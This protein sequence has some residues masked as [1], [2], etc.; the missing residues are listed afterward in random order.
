MKVRCQQQKPVASIRGSSAR[1]R[2]R[3]RNACMGREGMVTIASYVLVKGYASTVVDAVSARNVE[4]DQYAC[5]VVDAICALNVEGDQYASTVVD[6]VSARNVEGHQYASTVVYAVGARIVE[7]DQY[8]STVVNA[9]GARIAEGRRHNHKK[10]LL[11]EDRPTWP[12]VPQ[13]CLSRT[14]DQQVAHE[15]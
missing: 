9:V 13:W 14:E 15:R 2:G 5:T 11:D 8:A 6:A 10:K 4:V 7:G 12:R 1:R 3:G